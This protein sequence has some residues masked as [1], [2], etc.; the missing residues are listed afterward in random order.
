M[1]QYHGTQASL[2]LLRWRLG[3]QDYRG[4]D[5]GEPFILGSAR[6]SLHPSG[7]I[8]GSAQVRIEAAGRVWVVSGDYKRDADPTCA[9]FEPLRCDGF[10]TEATFGLPVYRW[11]P[12]ANEVMQLLEWWDQ[13]RDE[14]ST[15]LL[16]CYA[17]G[18]A[19]RILAELAAVLPE[20]ERANRTVMLHGAILP[21]V[22]I[23]RNAGVAM[24]PAAAL[25]SASAP[26]KIS[27]DVSY[28]GALVLAPPSAAG[29]PWMRRFKQVSTA[30]ASGWMRLRGNRKRRGFER[31][32]VLSDHADWPALLRTIHGTG[33]KRI[34]VTH[35][36][37]EA[38]VRL[39]SEHGIDAAGLAVGYADEAV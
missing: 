16:F 14:G 6:V 1:G 36:N 38:L 13:C 35:G 33:A 8:L 27:S 9:E 4:Y 3:E 11:R 26:R 19:Q 29:S 30:F 23:Y 17:L 20:R 25:P 15:A 5:Y 28:S 31:G 32:F 21:A 22:E 24:L 34:L 12:V 39:L 7:H 18:K 10:V 37:G 2:P